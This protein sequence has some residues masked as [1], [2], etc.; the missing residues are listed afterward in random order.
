MNRFKAQRLW[1]MDGSHKTNL[2]I[3]LQIY[4]C[5]QVQI[6]WHATKQTEGL[7]KCQWSPYSSFLGYHGHI[8][9]IVEYE[10]CPAQKFW[11]SVS[12]LF[13]IS[14]TSEEETREVENISAGSWKLRCDW[15]SSAALRLW[16]QSI[17]IKYVTSP[18]FPASSQ[19]SHTNCSGN[20]LSQVFQPKYLLMDL[21]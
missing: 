11:G 14:L 21:F 13:I 7:K 5:A 12:I 4:G 20:M 6:S 10:L 1:V 2:F 15:W 8:M 9:S 19:L 3:F 18:P 16:L 17:R